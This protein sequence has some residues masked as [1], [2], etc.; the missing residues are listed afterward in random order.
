MPGRVSELNQS[1]KLLEQDMKNGLIDSAAGD[2]RMKMYQDEKLMLENRLKITQSN[3]VESPEGINYLVDEYEK[4]KK[5]T[6]KAGKIPEAFGWFKEEVLKPNFSDLAYN[7][8]T[9]TVNS[10]GPS[11]MLHQ[12]KSTSERANS[13]ANTWRELKTKAQT[14][15]QTDS[16]EGKSS[17]SNVLTSD[18]KNSDIYKFNSTI[19][20]SLNNNSVDYLAWTPEGMKT[21]DD[22]KKDKKYKGLD[23]EVVGAAHDSPIYDTWYVQGVIKNKKTGQIL[24]NYDLMPKDQNTASQMYHDLNLSLAQDRG[25]DVYGNRAKQNLAHIEFPDLKT[26]NLNLELAG[27]DEKSQ[28]GTKT[29]STIKQ[30]GS[31]K[32]IVVREKVTIPIFNDNGDI[33]DYGSRVMNKSYLASPT[34]SAGTKITNQNIA[35]YLPNGELR[36]IKNPRYAADP[37]AVKYGLDNLFP[38]VEDLKSTLL[39]MK[40]SAKQ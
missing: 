4:Y 11:G 38:S 31:A 19:T 5:A 6:V 2:N 16:K 27:V 24:D 28:A 34:A 32:I 8:E 15:V 14:K 40:Y 33:V 23:I 25:N 21:F 7:T 13:L 18:D 9:K 37:V 22:I 17:Y 39:D 35:D 3:F 1:I 10:F 12:G 29:F 26:S 36:P 30:V 20:N